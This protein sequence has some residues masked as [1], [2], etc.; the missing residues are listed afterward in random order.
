MSRPN[1]QRW[2][3]AGGLLVLGAC[4][5]VPPDPGGGVGELSEGLVTNCSYLNPGPPINFD[6]ELV[7]RDVSVV[8]D[9][10]RSTN[11]PVGPCAPGT[12]G[13]WTFKKLMTEMA[14]STPV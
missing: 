4:N 9:A 1:P 12:V 13:V 10:C 11:T 6:Q 8:E 14:G 3:A 5:T 2:L 7:I